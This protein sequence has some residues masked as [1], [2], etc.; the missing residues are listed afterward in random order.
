MKTDGWKTEGLESVGGGKTKKKKP[1]KGKSETEE[2][3]FIWGVNGW[4]LR[5]VIAA[6]LE[7]T[8]KEKS[9]ESIRILATAELRKNSEGG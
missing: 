4:G 3:G 2:K 6:N 5:E 7:W 1:A 9:K 8:A